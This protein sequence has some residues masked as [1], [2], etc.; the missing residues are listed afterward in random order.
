MNTATVQ[1]SDIINNGIY[2]TDGARWWDED[3]SFFTL[4]QSVNPVRVSYSRKRLLGGNGSGFLGKKALE[5]GCGGGLLTEEIA[6]M[7]FVATGI[8]PAEASIRT[9]REHA[10]ASGLGIQYDHGSGEELPYPDNAFDAVFCCDVLEHVKDVNSVISEISR[11]LKPGGSFIFDTFNRTFISK[12]V[13]I[14]LWQDWKRWAF[15]EPNAH[16]WDMFIKPAEM[17]KM[18]ERNELEPKHIS[19]TKPN[20]PLLTLLGNLRK[21]AAG[22][23]TFREFGDS[24]HLVEDRD[25]N[26]MYLGHAVK[27]SV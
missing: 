9:A 5:V 22:Q 23:W 27:R 8:D 10:R 26:I 11:V 16:V 20:I 12:V 19:G 24:F 7:G 18:L 2:E 3:N 1:Y 6:K 4:R 15:M 17:E 21:R 13:V 25:V 14:K